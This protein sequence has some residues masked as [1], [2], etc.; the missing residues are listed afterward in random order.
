MQTDWIDRGQRCRSAFQARIQHVRAA[1]SHTCSRHDDAKSTR[2]QK[3]QRGVSLK[4][5]QAGRATYCHAACTDTLTVAIPTSNI[6]EQTRTV[7]IVGLALLKASLSLWN[8]PSQVVVPSVLF[9]P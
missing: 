1:L 2:E 8:K 5:E 7:W 3:Q 4:R 9:P 6:P